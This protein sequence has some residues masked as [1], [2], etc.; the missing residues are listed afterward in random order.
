MPLTDS[1]DLLV[2]EHSARAFLRLLLLRYRLCFFLY[3]EGDT[4]CFIRLVGAITAVVG[5]GHLHC[6]DVINVA[7]TIHRF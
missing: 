4:A 2:S 6:V 1:L 3:F 7:S 5:L